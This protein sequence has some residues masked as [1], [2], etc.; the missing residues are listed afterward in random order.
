MCGEETMSNGNEMTTNDDSSAATCRCV[1]IV[2]QGGN[3]MVGGDANDVANVIDAE[4]ARI[5]AQT[6]LEEAQL[7]TMEFR[8][9]REDVEF[10]RVSSAI[11]ELKQSMQSDPFA[12][13]FARFPG[14]GSSEHPGAD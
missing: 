14:F 12:G 6:R 8:A 5:E 9:S 3:L 13:L 2:S 7:R 1:H 10:E 4:T 11:D